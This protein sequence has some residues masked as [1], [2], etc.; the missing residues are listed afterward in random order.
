MIRLGMVGGG[1]G[2]FIGGV[3]R[4]A[5]RLDGRFTLV[6]GA[7]SSDPERSRRMGAELG[8]YPA[9]VYESYE[10]MAAA[11]AEL[12]PDRRIEAVSIVTPNDLH[13]PAAMAFLE[14]GI[15]VICDKPLT[16]TLSDAE[17]LC[18]EAAE[19][20]LVFC[21]T[22]NYSGYPM[23]KEA[24]ERV[25]AGELGELRKVVVEYSQGWLSTLLE[26]ED[27]KQASWRADPERAGVSSALGDIGSHA[28]HLARYVTGLGM[29]ELFADL[30]TL[31]EGRVLEDDATV[32]IRYEDGV[33]GVLMASQ[34]SAG[35]RN[36]LRLRVYGSRG[37][38]DWCQ[39]RPDRLRLAR[40]D[41]T[42]RILHDGADG[43][44]ARAA[45]HQ[46]LPAGHPEGFIEAFANLY[47]NVAATLD[48]RAGRAPAGPFDD[49]FP[50]VEDGARGVFFIGR[51]V[52]SGKAGAWLAAN[53]EPPG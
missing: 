18:R 2:A 49:D 38:L 24:R 46:R 14:A 45:A 19:R 13:H 47:R 4:M 51:A 9:R 50:T 5:A 7:F 21:V 48:A 42:E 29:E 22:H 16:T 1:P 25:R 41:G 26:A 28:H 43:L 39:E 35:E 53:Y 3:H 27:H 34:I 6:A 20:S 31:V 17:E 52:E 15:H 44:S 23:V 11:E 32:L 36:H 12:P 30:G 33:R 8:L 37:G 40:P 10:E